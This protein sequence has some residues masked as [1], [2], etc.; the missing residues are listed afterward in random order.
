MLN[1]RLPCSESEFSLGNPQLGNVL[2]STESSQSIFGELVKAMALWSAV[3]ALIKKSD[4]SFA[5]RLV[6]IQ[7][8]DG[9][10][11]EARSSLD[12]YFHLSCGSM[13]S[14][15]PDDLSKLLLLH[16]IYHQ[17]FCSIHSSI[18]PLFSWSACDGVFSYAHQLSA[19]TAFEHAN[20]VSALLQTALNLSW[21]SRRMPS[22][23]GYAA[24]C[25]CAIQTPFLWCSQPDVKQR[26][27]C[28]ILAN[29]KTLQIVGRNWEFIKV[30]V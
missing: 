22:F 27:V 17:C 24:Y 25:A 19:Q 14:V 10:I 2:K 28:N 13:S 15:S 4:S 23:I 21:D 29:L 20:S 18:V 5:S 30:L 6:E 8:L 9:R 1:M 7:N 3:V 16:I 12:K 11:H 26:A